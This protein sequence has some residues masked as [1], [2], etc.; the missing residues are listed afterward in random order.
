[1]VAPKLGENMRKHYLASLLAFVLLGVSTSAFAFSE[2]SSIGH[3]KRVRGS[4]QHVDSKVFKLVRNGVI[5]AQGI[6]MVSGD[7]VI[8]DTTSDDG[9]TVAL[10]TTSADGAFAGICVTA[11][12]SSDGTTTTTSALDDI[13]R[14]N[15]GYIQVHGRALAKVSAGGQNAAAPGDLFITSGDSGAVTTMLRVA[16]TNTTTTE[17]GKIAQGRGGFFYDAADGTSTMV[18]V[19]IDKE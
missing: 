12:P 13:G 18:E 15:W 19:Q 2:P 11:I 1:M 4:D 3:N 7:A 16:G 5:G 10:T 6:S 17:L 14:R 9:V 8:Y